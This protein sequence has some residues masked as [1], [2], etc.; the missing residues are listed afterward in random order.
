MWKQVFIYP[1]RFIVLF[2]WAS[3]LCVRGIRRQQST[4]WLETDCPTTS[5][6]LG[7]VII[8][9]MDTDIRMDRHTD[10]TTQ[11][12]WEKSFRVSGQ[13]CSLQH[14]SI[15]I[16]EDFGWVAY[17]LLLRFIGT[18]S[19]FG[20]REP[21][22]KVI[23]SAGFLVNVLITWF[24]LVCCLFNTVAATYGLACHYVYEGTVLQCFWV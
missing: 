10:Y 6:T 12:W 7:W 21:V 9:V 17:T 16:R 4:R 5:Y 15:C 20:D 22:D 18:V 23:L 3:L 2:L 8:D 1:I 11:Q 13:G 19:V 14:C 24:L